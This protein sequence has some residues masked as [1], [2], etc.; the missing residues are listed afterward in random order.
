MSYTVHWNKRMSGQKAHK[1][2][3][4][5]ALRDTSIQM[6][7]TTKYTQGAHKYHLVLSLTVWWWITH[8]QH[9]QLL[10]YK[11]YPKSVASNL[12][13]YKNYLGTW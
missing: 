4:Q 9:T 12:T 10:K 3:I 13:T 7:Y 5:Q 8:T 11:N 6:I 2:V 1:N